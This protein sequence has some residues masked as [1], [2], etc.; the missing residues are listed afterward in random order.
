MH[1]AESTKALHKI[2]NSKYS[3][4]LAIRKYEE[5]QLEEFEG[6]VDPTEHNAAQSKSLHDY[7]K[8]LLDEAEGLSDLLE[9]NALRA[10]ALRDITDNA[11]TW[12]RPL[13]PPKHLSFMY[14]DIRTAAT[15]KFVEKDDGQ[16]A[17]A[18]P[19]HPLHK[20]KGSQSAPATTNVAPKLTYYRSDLAFLSEGNAPSEPRKRWEFLAGL[21]ENRLKMT[22]LFREP[23]REF[24]DGYTWTLTAIYDKPVANLSDSTK[25]DLEG[26]MCLPGFAQTQEEDIN[27]PIMPAS[28]QNEL[29]ILSLEGMR[30]PNEPEIYQHRIA[31]RLKQ[32]FVAAIKA[33]D[34][35]EPQDRRKLNL[36]FITNKYVMAVHARLLKM[37]NRHWS[38]HF[39]YNGV[40]GALEC[41]GR[42]VDFTARRDLFKRN[43]PSLYQCWLAAKAW[44]WNIDNLE[45]DELK[46]D[47]NHRND[48]GAAIEKL[49]RLVFVQKPHPPKKP[50][51]S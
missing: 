26:I 4:D 21:M 15:Y 19:I 33:L 50:R 3:K 40:R 43:S 35:L 8:A 31:C 42:T 37:E 38:L 10:V 44:R 47:R 11:A 17:S 13:H 20:L 45:L 48:R 46:H 9:H 28:P 1:E 6:N 14:T 30:N 18:V 32:V 34:D 16:T 41:Y 12:L 29:A 23:P 22:S 24:E 51:D 39:Q 25:L 5:G 7:E 27:K 36:S 2:T 49:E